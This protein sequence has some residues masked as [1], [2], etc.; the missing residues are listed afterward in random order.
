MSHCLSCMSQL[1][2][3]LP[4]LILFFLCLFLIHI[5]PSAAC[6]FLTSSPWTLPLCRCSSPSVLRALVLLFYGWFTLC[7]FSSKNMVSTVLRHQWVPLSS[8]PTTG[9]SW[10]PWRRELEARIT[11]SSQR[12]PGKSQ[13]QSPFEN[14]AVP[15]SIQEPP[16][17]FLTKAPQGLLPA[18]P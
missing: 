2:F 17:P 16:G 9:S 11:Q 12:L 7:P 18:D 10:T 5:L 6:S 13:S 4:F 3:S 15:G 8:M 1:S 14:P